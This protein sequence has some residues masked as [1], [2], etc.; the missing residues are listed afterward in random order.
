MLLF[1][2]ALF[3][4]SDGTPVH[5]LFFA[6][7]NLRLVTTQT[8]IIAIGAL[9]MAII[10]AGGGVDLGAQSTLLMC[11]TLTAI[12]LREHFTPVNATLLAIL[13]GAIVGGVNGLVITLSRQPA[14]LAT[15]GMAGITTGVAYWL[16][17]GSSIPLIPSWIDELMPALVRPLWMLLA[18][19]A[20]IALLLAAVLGMIMHG[21]I[22]GR[23]IVAVGS[24]A[25]AASLYGVRVGM[26]R[27]IVYLVGGFYF[28]M[29]GVLQLAWARQANPH[30][31]W[32]LGLNILLAVMLGGS[33]FTQHRGYIGGALL[34]ALIVTALQ[35]ALQHAG[36]PP[37]AQGLVSGFLL[38]LG[39]V[40]ERVEVSKRY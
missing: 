26:I 30:A 1:G 28:G 12:L 33:S 18:P 29:A 37:G 40:F 19:G 7:D 27:V 20:W 17:D 23:Q 9:G 14:W 32:G 22:L 36:V 31:D 34:G 8:A 2:I 3:Q 35:N 6:G 4:I 25:A 5:K 38:L 13:A 15:F 21:M 16:S 10:I 24:N 39:L 11:S